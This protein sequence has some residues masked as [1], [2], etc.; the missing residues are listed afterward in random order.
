MTAPLLAP[1]VPADPLDFEVPDTL[2]AT[3]PPEALGI[4]RDGVGLMVSRVADGT[5]THTRFS[6]LPELLGA[7]DLLVVN[8][9]ATINAALDAW[10]EPGPGIAPEPVALHLSSPVPG[11][12]E[13]SWVVE[14][15]RVTPEGTLPLSDRARRRASPSGSWRLG[16]T[17]RAVSSA[18]PLGRGPAGHRRGSSIRA[19]ARVAH[20]IPERSP[21]LAAVRLSNH[22]RG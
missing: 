13:G 17:D 7:G 8:A 4:P 19:G 16:K 22:L 21:A 3:D 1:T 6:A 9:S 11:A 5:V 12:R 20:P 10:R 2:V 18:S 15:R 14:L